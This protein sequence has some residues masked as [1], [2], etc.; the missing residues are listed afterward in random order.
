MAPVLFINPS[1]ASVSLYYNTYVGTFS[2]LE[3][4]A[5][6]PASCNQLTTKKPRQTKPLLSEEFNL[7]ALNLSSKQRKRAR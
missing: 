7:E 6:Q 3:D 4:G 1:P 2:Q 5:L